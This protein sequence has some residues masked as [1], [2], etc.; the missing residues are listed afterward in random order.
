MPAMQASTL[1]HPQL[2]RAP[3]FDAGLIARYD[4]NGPRYTSYPTAPHFHERFTHEDLRRI[5]Q[6]SNEDPIPRAL[7]VYVHIP[8][9]LSPCFYCG[10]TRIITRDRTRADSY[11]GHLLREIEMTAPLF[12]TDRRVDQL[13]LGG[14][15]P[16]FLDDA[17]MQRLMTALRSG[18]NLSVEADREFG[19]EVDPRY[20]DADTVRMLAEVGFNRISLGI[21]DFDI[22]VQQAVNRV[23]SVEQTRAVIEA[24]RDGG[25]RSVSVDLIHGLPKQTTEKF[26]RTLEQVIA[27]HPDRIATYSYA[28]MPERFRAQNQINAADLPDAS[29]RLALIGQ[30]V[31][32]L[33]AA[34]YRYIGLDHFALPADDLSRAQRQGTMQRNFQGYSTHGDCDLIGL[35]MSSIGHVGRSFHQN[36]R[37]LQEYYSA[38][39]AGVLPVQR[40]MLLGDDDVIR[41]DVIQQLMCHGELDMIE[42]GKH[43]GIDFKDYFSA[44]MSR[45]KALETDGLV[46]VTARGLQITARGRFL[47]RIVAM[48]FDAYL[49]SA[50]AGARP[51]YSK[52]L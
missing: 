14:G 5:A 46:Q 49:Q 4:I 51:G 16:N 1:I 34:G 47:L 11:L 18:F 13:H 30:T 23:Q 12:D 9:C 40:G 45:L 38:I 25:F 19:I 48:C 31:Q 43:Y 36:A 27:L 39:E 20:C 6:A 2:A 35:G 3:V 44:E 26:A 8:F 7:S 33:G 17:Q 28:H 52:A 42:F 15:T 29:T 21:Q 32:T 10:C 24:A 50:T 41:A 22:D 37:N